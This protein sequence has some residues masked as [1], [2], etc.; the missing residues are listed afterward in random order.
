M[1]QPRS[2]NWPTTGR[3][4]G[5]WQLAILR[6]V[7]LTNGGLSSGDRGRALNHLSLGATARNEQSASR[8]GVED[9]NPHERADTACESGQRQQR[10][11][12]GVV[13]REGGPG[14]EQREQ[15][16]TRTDRDDRDEPEGA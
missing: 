8:S 16:Q 9:D 5:Q 11:T 1:C 3:S 14:E 6:Q 2:D 13:N 15:H 10:S 12:F 7:T 4:P